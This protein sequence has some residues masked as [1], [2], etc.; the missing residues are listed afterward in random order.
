MYKSCFWC[1]PVLA[2]NIFKIN[3]EQL[4]LNIH[5][6]PSSAFGSLFLEYTPNDT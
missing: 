4:V 1:S 6:L 5:L 2:I 3:T